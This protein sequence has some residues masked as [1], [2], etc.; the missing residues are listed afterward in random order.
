MFTQILKDAGKALTTAALDALSGWLDLPIIETD[1]GPGYEF[2]TQA[3]A[4][5]GA[6]NVGIAGSAAVAVITGNTKAYLSDSTSR[7]LYPVNVTGVL[8]IDAYARQSLKSVA[9]SAVGDDGMADKNLTA[10]GSSDTGDGS[11]AG[12][13]NASTTLGQFVM[14][15]CKTARSRQRQQADRARRRLQAQRHAESRRSVTSASSRSPKRRRQLHLHRADGAD[16]LPADATINI[17]AA[18]SRTQEY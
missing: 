14:A 17:S 1:L 8:E 16:A 4:G 9:S 15:P 3:V 6:S 10:G 7:T 13:Q 2:I 11:S 18:L 12:T 5:A